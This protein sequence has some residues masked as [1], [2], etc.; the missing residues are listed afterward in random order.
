MC[1][2]T[3]IYP[4]KDLIKQTFT[5]EGIF[6]EQPPTLLFGMSGESNIIIDRQENVLIIPREFIN[7]KSQVNTKEGLINV[8]TGLKDMNNI[9]ILE[10]INLE[11]K[12]YPIDED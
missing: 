5:V 11:T 10:G 6:L 7:D 2:V 1:E 12:I 3:K 8:K 9:Q 4:Q